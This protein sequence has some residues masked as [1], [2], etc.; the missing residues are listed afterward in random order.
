MTSAG[1]RLDST[2]N[3]VCA[4]LGNLESGVDLVGV[5]VCAD[6]LESS[7]VLW[8][9]I[10]AARLGKVGSWNGN[11][12]KRKHGGDSLDGGDVE[13]FPATQVANVPP[14]VVVDT[15]RCVADATNKRRRGVGGG[16]ILHNGGGGRNGLESIEADIGEG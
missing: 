13:V 10:L 1:N 16:E 4:T 7:L 12:E 2:H 14:E 11:L 6:I 5:V 15:A 3:H 8:L 9:E